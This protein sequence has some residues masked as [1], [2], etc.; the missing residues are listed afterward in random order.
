MAPYFLFV[1][2][3][4][5][6]AVGP[7]A[8]RYV[9]TPERRLSRALAS[10]GDT[11]DG[12][13]PARDPDRVTGTVLDAGAADVLVMGVHGVPKARRRLR[14]KAR[15]VENGHEPDDVPVQLASFVEASAPTQDEREARARLDEIGTLGDLQQRWVDEGLSVLNRAIR[16]HRAGASDPYVVEV[17]RRDARKVRIGYGT[18]QEVTDGGWTEALEIP[19]PPGHRAT[20]ASSLAPA[21]AVA[22]ALTGRLSVLACEDLLVRV[23]LDLDHGR[24]QAA[25]LQAEAGL[26]LLVAETGTTDDRAAEAVRAA[27]ELARTAL[28]RELTEPEVQRLL[29][30][31]EAGTRILESRRHAFHG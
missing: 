24:S 2:F 16:A 9:V 7:G 10:T 19:P 11:G 14:R 21:E 31:V 1:Q 6:H 12:A 17:L 3:E 23:F 4:F 15:L 8:G 25:A 20:R 18:T 28:E 29:T 27:G 5:T 22:D 13:S 30:I 26:R